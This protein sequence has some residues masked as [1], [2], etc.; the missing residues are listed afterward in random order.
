M[1][2]K[3][4]FIIYV[5][6]EEKALCCSQDCWRTQNLHFNEI[7]EEKVEWWGDGEKKETKN[8]VL[9]VVRQWQN[10]PL[11]DAYCVRIMI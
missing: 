8:V 9:I 4:I 5:Y 11:I 6:D 7:D 10:L 3:F 2:R 1:H